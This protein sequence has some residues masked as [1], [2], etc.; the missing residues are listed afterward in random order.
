M[1]A[2]GSAHITGMHISSALTNA[3]VGCRCSLIFQIPQRVHHHT[4]CA[5]R[6][7]R[8]E[9]LYNF[10]TEPDFSFASDSGMHWKVHTCSKR[11]TQSRSTVDMNGY[12]E[13]MSMSFLCCSGNFLIRQ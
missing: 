2:V 9:E 7:R 6:Q 12:F 13:V 11:I 8:L 4:Q 10:V 3:C 5:V 1:L